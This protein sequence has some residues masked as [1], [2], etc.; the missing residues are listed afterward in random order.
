VAYLVRAD[1]AT[2]EG[3]AAYAAPDGLTSRPPLVITATVHL[4][5][6][7]KTI[8]VLNNHFTSMSAGEKPT[9]PRRK[10]QAAWNVEL[11]ERIQASDPDAAIAVLGDLNSFYD[12]PPV[13]VLRDASLRHV[14]EFVEPER[15]YTYIYQGESET[16]DHILVT[17]ALYE[18]L[19]EV[20][21]LHVNADYPPPI[22]GDPSARRT[23]DHD[24]LVVLFTL[25]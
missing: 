14:Y 5:D 15:P 3:A 21:V 4:Q 24:P 9:E 8:Y 23:S 2:V 22:P 7:D 16:L 25:K 19:E 1:Q 10:A 6:G 13:D 18:L 20:A 12:S 11:V 17:P